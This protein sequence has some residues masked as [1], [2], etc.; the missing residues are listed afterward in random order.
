MPR[1]NLQPG[2]IPEDVVADAAHTQ[3]PGESQR[4]KSSDALERTAEQG[5]NGE[6]GVVIDGQAGSLERGGVPRQ[7]QQSAGR[8][9]ASIVPC[10]C[11]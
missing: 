9:E 3:A 6:P 2:S 7:E 10:E 4:L 5:A 8:P 11:P 1:S